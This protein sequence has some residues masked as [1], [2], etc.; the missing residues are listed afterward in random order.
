[1]SLVNVKEYE[2]NIFATITDTSFLYETAPMYVTDQPA[3]INCGCLV[4]VPNPLFIYLIPEQIETNIPPLSLLHLLKHIETAVGRVSSIRNGPR[5]I[6]LDIVFYGDAV[7]DTRPPSQ[8]SNLDNLLGELVVP[9]P[10]MIEREF[11]LRPMNEY[12][13]TYLQ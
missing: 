4:R 13:L 3:F 9:H 8:R 10:R 11:V 6:D 12:V 1:M 7:V 2:S 5:T